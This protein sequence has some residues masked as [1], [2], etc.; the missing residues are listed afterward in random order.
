MR[1]G[2]GVPCLAL[3]ARIASASHGGWTQVKDIDSSDG[4]VEPMFMLRHD[5]ETLKKLDG[6]IADVS[7]PGSSNYGKYLDMAGV[8]KAFPAMEGASAAVMAFLAKKGVPESSISVSASGDIISASLQVFQ[9]Q[10]VFG[11]DFYTYEHP[12][13]QRRIIR[14][15]DTYNVSADIAQFVYL[16]GNLNEFPEVRRPKIVEGEAGE[17]T[18][19][20]SDCGSCRGRVTP[21]ILGQRYGFNSSEVLT[22]RADDTGM[23]TA[24][25]Q[26][27]Y[28]DNTSLDHFKSDCKLSQPVQVDQQVGNNYAWHCL[29]GGV[30]IEALLDIEY[31]KA[32]SGGIKLTNIFNSEYSLLNWAKQVDDLG[33]AGPA[34]HSISYGDDEVQQGD[35]APKGMSGKEYMDAVNSQFAKLAAR[36]VS[37]LV[38]AGDQGVCGRTGCG[39]VF[40]PD[41]PASSP[42]VTAVGGTDFVTRSVVGDEEA[43]Q[44][45]G[46]GF[47]NTFSTPEWQKKAVD[48]YLTAASKAG[49]L[50]A[51]AKFNRTGRAYPDVSALGG[52]KNPYCIAAKGFLGESMQGVAGT[53]ASSPVVAGIVARLNSARLAKGMPRM[54]FLNPF[55]YQHPEVF[56]DVTKGVN[57]D[58]GSSGFAALEGW[59]PATGMGTPN[60]PAMLKAALAERLDEIV[61]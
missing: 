47:S 61:V 26:G 3:A 44:S 19:F 54:G 24:E 53:S 13:T 41:F 14:A 28:Y 56:H 39:S 52:Q 10:E 16:V 2:L 57:S 22:L 37:V 15:A 51:A 42:Y 35:D 50:P 27:V 11:V 12:R 29:T 7:T 36:G 18:V 6:F 49:N 23:A 8:A 58:M 20:G 25:F 17:N 21:D 48:A 38:A 4:S 55:I 34:V 1:F 32:A 40:H 9:A 33:D 5:P 60:F 46:G 45:G 43:W 59:D 31:G 30:C